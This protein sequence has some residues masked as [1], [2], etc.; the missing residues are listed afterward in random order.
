MAGKNGSARKRQQEGAAAQYKC[1][2]EAHWTGHDAIE[3]H[4][5]PAV[6]LVIKAGGQM[7][8]RGQRKDKT[9]AKFMQALLGV[10][11]AAH[12]NPPPAVPE[13]CK[14]AKELYS[15]VGPGGLRRRHGQRAGPHARSRAWEGPV[16]RACAL[17]GAVHQQGEARQGVEGAGGPAQGQA[18]QRAVYHGGQDAHDCGGGTGGCSCAVCGWRLSARRLAVRG[19]LAAGRNI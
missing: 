10:T 3:H 12:A 13:E 7:G 16:L 2:K 19:R 5:Q 1:C 14:R 8:G 4:K 17:P 18:Q 15:Q 11:L 9:A 6:W